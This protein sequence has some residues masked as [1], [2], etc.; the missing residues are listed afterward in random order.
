M[1]NRLLF[2]ELETKK[3]LFS[4][5]ANPRDWPAGC[6][7]KFIIN[8]PNFCKKFYNESECMYKNKS[9]KRDM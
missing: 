6:T 7:L 1:Q 8:S 2:F 3:L 4:V 5:L 9:S